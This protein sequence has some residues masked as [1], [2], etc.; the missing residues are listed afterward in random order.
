Q[1][2]L[3]LDCSLALDCRV[4]PR[5]DRECRIDDTRLAGEAVMRARHHSAKM[6]GLQL[7]GIPALLA[8]TSG[9]GLISAFVGDGLW[10]ALSWF[11]LGAPLAVIACFVGRATWDVGGHE[12]RH[13]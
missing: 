11:A 6:R 13:V 3:S 7:F 4:V 8:T 10:D 5:I 1:R 2:T 9:F 12:A